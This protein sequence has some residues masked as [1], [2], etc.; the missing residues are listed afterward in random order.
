MENKIIREI[1][2]LSIKGFSE[3]HSL[4]L[5]QKETDYGIKALSQTNSYILLSDRVMFK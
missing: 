5:N 1:I 3:S 2:K 4:I